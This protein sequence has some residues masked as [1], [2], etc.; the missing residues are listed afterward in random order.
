MSGTAAAVAVIMVVPGFR[1]VTSPVTEL[2]VATLVSLLVYLTVPVPTERFAATVNGATP[3]V[4]VSVALGNVIVCGEPLPTVIFGTSTK[5]VLLIVMPCCVPAMLLQTALVKP[6]P[7]VMPV[8]VPGAT[9]P[10][11]V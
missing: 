4:L 1:I 9:L 11:A 2:T 6:L 3:K 10:P 7:R 5:V 8:V